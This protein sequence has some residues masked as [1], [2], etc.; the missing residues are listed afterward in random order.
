M[1]A[2]S[3]PEVDHASRAVELVSIFKALRDRPANMQLDDA[4]ADLLQIKKSSRSFYESIGAIADSLDRLEQEIH[5]SRL[6]E[7]SKQT[8]LEAADDLRRYVAIDQIRTLTSD[9]LKNEEDAF[10]LLTL[11]DDVLEPIGNRG[12]PHKVLAEWQETLSSL[13]LDASTSIQ[14]PALREFVINQI[15]SVYWAISNY[16]Y[17]GIDGIS[18]NYGAMAAELARSRGMKGAGEAETKS[19]YQRAKKPIIA[20]GIGIAAAGAVVEQ[21]DNLLTHG[22]NVYEALTGGDPDESRSTSREVVT[23]SRAKKP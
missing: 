7:A 10:R 4:W 9:H 2:T 1:A 16:D 8:Y 22:G 3:T 14:N 23:S 5:A 15:S 21:A 20:L 18:R 11:L 17:I 13:I 6:K 12:I 19:W